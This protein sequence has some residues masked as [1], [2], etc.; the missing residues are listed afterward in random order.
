MELL[1]EGAAYDAAA[2]LREAEGNGVVATVLTEKT[3]SQ[4]LL[5]AQRAQATFDT[6]AIVCAGIVGSCTLT[7]PDAEA[8]LAALAAIPNMRGIRHGYQID[9][10]GYLHPADA[11]QPGLF[12]DSDFR[13]GFGMLSA[14][15]FSFDACLW[16][17]QLPELLELAR[18]FPEQLIVLN[19]CGSPVGVGP[20]GGAKAGDSFKRWAG[21]ITDLAGCP[22]VVCKIGGLLLVANGHGFESYDAAPTSAAVAA[23]IK[24]FVDHV[25][26]AFGF[27]RCLFES[28]FP[29]DRGAVGY[30]VL[31]NAYK[32]VLAGLSEAE[33]AAVFAGNARRVYRLGA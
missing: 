3:G 29:V 30:T 6:T 32:R 16:F 5:E 17:E 10:T 15:G 11:G 28:N 8:Q 4:P 25:V 27:R 13:R 31:V 12:A 9:P 21:F 1:R 33:Q 24:P 18:A 19:H 23:Y 14:H 22:N 26:D 20:W 7:A 2:L